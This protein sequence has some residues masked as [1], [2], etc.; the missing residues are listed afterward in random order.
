MAKVHIT[1]DVISRAN[2]NFSPVVVR[3]KGRKVIKEETREV[4]MKKLRNFGEKYITRKG[5]ITKSKKYNALPTCRDRINDTGRRNIFK[6]FW[7]IGLYEK[8][9]RNEA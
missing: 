1:G 9:R 7:G 8:R 5:K 4:P 2:E 3:K 6:G